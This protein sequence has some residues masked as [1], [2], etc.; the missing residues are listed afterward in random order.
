[1]S[2]TVILTNCSGFTMAD[3]LYWTDV[4]CTVGEEVLFNTR[5]L[6]QTAN[7]T[8]GCCGTLR[9]RLQCLISIFRRD[10]RMIEATRFGIDFGTTNS[11][12]AFFDGQELHRPLLDPGSDNPLVLPS[13]LYINRQQQPSIGT[14]AARQYMQNE[15]GR[16]AQWEKRRVGEIDVVAA[17]VNYV[18]TVHALV[19]VGAQG[20]L[21]QYVKTALRD[22]GYD[23]TQVFDRFYT[24]DELIAM[25][26]RALKD[27]AE[28]QLQSTCTNIVLGRPVKFSADPEVTERAQEIL[29]KAARLAGFQ[30]VRFELEPIGAL[31]FYHRSNPKR[32]LAFIFDFGGGT[33][34]LTLAEVGGKTL[35]KVIATQGV[36][37]GGD[38]LDRRLMQLLLK[39]FG[40]VPLAGRRA[41][42]PDVLDLLE[43]WQTMPL[44]SR[45]HFLKLVGAYR[46]DNPAA[47]DALLT[48][49]TRNLGFSLFRE[50]EQAKIRL[51]NAYVTDLNFSF[52]NID[53]RESITRRR[54]ED[55]IIHEVETVEAGIRQILRDAA[56]D[57]ERVDVVLRTGGTSAV[58]AFSDLLATIFDGRKLR[59]LELLTSVV[60][61]LA[62]A[63]YEDRGT[64]PA[65]EVIYPPDH[66]AVIHSIR[67]PLR[68]DYETY[69]FRI[70]ARC[71]LDFTYSVSRLPVALSGLPTVRVAQADKAVES[72][73]FLQFDL[74]RPAKI[75]VAYDADARSVPDWLGT[76]TPERMTVEV[77]QVGTS[78]LF[79]VFSKGYQAGT[80]VLGGNR[81]SGSTG[82]VFMNYLVIIRPSI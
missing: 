21:L 35:P 55:L 28:R 17:G 26:L 3:S 80:V 33:L 20:R 23:G 6:L 31:F 74:S 19:D 67:S 48:L 4:T 62:I 63:A 2:S 78:R 81:S 18:Q 32:E 29:Y 8:L 14:A 65:Y 53:V 44:L 11:S 71:Y 46:K 15:T 69:E 54:F 49:V 39:Y 40:G 51:S 79:N 58:P 82:N 41:L 1:M 7:D 9:S 47:I 42:P 72:A 30:D 25:I 56:I 36:L 64:S 45:P 37:V 5:N 10:N 50:I 27:S 77:D 66:A 76:F 34:D 70:G 57:P 75:Y 52:A 13:L 60:G 16:R 61:G 24:V 38:N 59:T 43:N 73:E 12:I 22:P 68:Q